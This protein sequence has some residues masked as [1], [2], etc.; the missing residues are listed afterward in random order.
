MQEP[1]LLPIA[2]FQDP[3]EQA[4]AEGNHFSEVFDILTSQRDAATLRLEPCC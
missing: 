3:V 4:N 2:G 1:K